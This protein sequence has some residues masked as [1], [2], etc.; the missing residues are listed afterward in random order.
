MTAVVRAKLRASH[1]TMLD[2]PVVTGTGAPA[3]LTAAPR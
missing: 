3:F 2:A 1:I